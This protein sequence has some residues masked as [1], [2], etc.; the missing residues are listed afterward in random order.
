MD[1]RLSQGTLNREREAVALRGLRRARRGVIHLGR[2]RTLGSVFEGPNSRA[3]L[4]R[5]RVYRRML[6][7]AD[8]VAVFA[9]LELSVVATGAGPHLHLVVLLPLLAAAVG[10]AKFLG[11]YDRDDL[12]LHKST[13]NEAPTVFHMATL[14]A[15]LVELSSWQLLGGPLRPAQLAAT[16]A[17]VFALTLVTRTCARG[18]SHGV[19]RPERCLVVGDLSGVNALSSRLVVG[20]GV[21]ADLIGTLVLGS[22]ANQALSLESI[23]Q[24]V[25]DLDVQRVILAPREADSDLVLD[26][27]RLVKGLGV[28]VSLLPRLFEVVGSSVVFDDLHGI[29]LLGVR[30][31]GLS[32]SSAAIKRATDV[33]VALIGLAAVSPIMAIVALLI[34]ADTPGPI[35]FRQIRVGRDGERFEMLK[36]RSMVADADAQ[37]TELVERHGNSNG[38]GRLFKLADD[39]RVT[40]VG[41]WLRRTSL[42]ELPQLLNVLRGDMSL[43]GPR[44]LIVDEDALVRGWQRRRLRL[45]PG[46]TGPWQSLGSTA[47]LN[48]MIN[49]DYLYIANW[50]LYADVKIVLRTAMHVLGR[51]GV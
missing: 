7:V 33:T 29:T 38:N 12:V 51:N 18:I 41:K 14:F 3:I 8:V 47:P 46:M 6:V 15:L 27:V 10:T 49:M 37:R 23:E 4:R 9:A 44:P 42:D 5:D 22:G 26:V 13:L 20:R 43:V 11:L 31:F 40:R 28:K 32:R 21:N 45:T 24:M 36:F 50:S 19:A 35:F 30:R 2:P 39:P 17:L 34:R 48:E 25:R 16:W 1:G